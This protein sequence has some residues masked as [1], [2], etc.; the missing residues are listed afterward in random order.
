VTLAEV[1]ELQAAAREIYVDELI[2]QWIVELVRAS[3]E[4][5]VVAVGAS[6]RGTLALEHAGRGLA[7]LSGRSFV[8]PE[9][10]E[11]LLLP[12]LGHRIVFKPLFLAEARKIGWEASM[13]LF[14]AALLERAP[15]PELPDGELL[16]L[17]RH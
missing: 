15:R 4:L 14:R 12:V 6:V 8:V 13:E 10:V 17:E 9:D 7:L 1:K 5:D 11:R 3:R 2:Q 16:S